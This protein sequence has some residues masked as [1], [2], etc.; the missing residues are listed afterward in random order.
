MEQKLVHILDFVSLYVV[1]HVTFLG[2]ES[3]SIIQRDLTCREQEFTYVVH[4]H[5]LLLK[6]QLSGS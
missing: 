6:I 4:H 1:K 3:V 2:V 5:V